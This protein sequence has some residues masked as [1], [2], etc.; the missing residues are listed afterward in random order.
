MTTHLTIKRRIFND[1]YFPDLQDYSSRV[2]IF[3][4]GAGS[5]KSHYIA[6]KLLIKA[7]QEK[8]KVLVLR[9][10]GRTVATSIFQLLLER[11]D[12]F[13]IKSDCRIN[14]TNFTIELPNGSLFLC[15]G[16]DDSEKIKSIVGIT[17]IWMEEASEFTQEDF[18]QLDLRL[19]HP[20]A[21]GQ[22]IILSFNPISKAS[23]LYKLF[24]EETSE[25]EALKFREKVK[26]HHSNYRDNRFLP[27]D[28][29]DS[30]MTLKTTNPAY[31][32]IYVEGEFGSLDKLVY[33][34]WREEDFNKDE[35]EGVLL[36][37]LDFGYVND[38][39]AFIASILNEEQKKVYIFKC[40][41]STG[42]LNNEIAN[43]IKE[44]GFAKSLI[45]ADSAEPKS[46]EEIRRLGV[47]RIQASTKGPG[48]ILQGINKVQQYELIVHPSCEEVKVELLN[49]SWKKD[50]KSGEYINEPVDDWNHFLDA[51][52]YSFQ[53]YSPN[54]RLSTIDKKLL[55]L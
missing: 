23:W 13:K 5:G 9:K 54:K 12:F 45:I 53:C 27:Q 4:G 37:G 55:G 22:Q 43:K 17:D 6:D 10:V 50:R 29:I 16:L 47:P 52:R 39:T 35:I 24:F 36:L 32:G 40:W 15:S 48:S 14:K 21:S 41:G 46:I 33:Q 42:L 51:L 11:L 18:N 31:Y 25:A 30:L 7:L 1:S 49:Y 34:N 8:R 20:K 26:I 19:R 44:D 3:Y 28:Y 2:A 38:K